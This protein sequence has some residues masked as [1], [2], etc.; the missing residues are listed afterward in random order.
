MSDSKLTTLGLV[1]DLEGRIVEAV[2]HEGSYPQFQAG[3]HFVYYLDTDSIQRFL[4]YLKDT[5]EHGH[6]FGGELLLNETHGHLIL[7]VALLKT[8]TQIVMLSLKERQE[9]LTV[10]S[11]IIR[12]NSEQLNSLRQAQAFKHYSHDEATA[13]YLREWTA[14]NSELVNTQRELAQKNRELEKLNHILHETSM[15]DE[16][17]QLKNRRAFFHDVIAC[18]KQTIQRLVMVDLNGFKSINDR[19][20]H[21]QGDRVLKA[22]AHYIDEHIQPYGGEAYRLG[23]DEFAL[24]IPETNMPDLKTW[25]TA[26]DQHL[27]TLDATLSAAYGDSLLERNSL[28]ADLERAMMQADE[29]MYRHKALRNK[30]R[31]DFHA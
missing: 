23:G 28:L 15:R 30:K 5:L 18:S 20:G 29:R 22:F 17:T 6:S 19:L 3:T 11:E 12:I 4:D 1:L 14:L 24:T 7:S 8:G 31:H 13:A 27:V 26:L 21:H 16:L 10:L 2:K 25:M 9:T